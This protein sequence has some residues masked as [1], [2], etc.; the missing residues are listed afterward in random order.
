[1]T[2]DLKHARE[3]LTDPDAEDCERFASWY[4][5]ALLD[6]IERLRVASK[7]PSV[8]DVARI[9]DPYAFREGA[10]LDNHDRAYQ[11]TALAKATTILA[12]IRGEGE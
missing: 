3:L 5:T 9:I 4:G 6:E 8:E 12:L 11:K 7:L 2:L 1:M 10:L